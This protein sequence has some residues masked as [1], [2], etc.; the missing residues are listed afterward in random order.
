[1]SPESV[2]LKVPSET[3][4]WAEID[5][6]DNGLSAARIGLKLA[7]TNS[8]TNIYPYE[9]VA[10]AA[11]PEEARQAAAQASP[12]PE[13]EEA[14][15]DALDL[16]FAD[17][18]EAT[19]GNHL[20]RLASATYVRVETPL[21]DA[22]ATWQEVKRQLALPE[23]QSVPDSQVEV[24]PL[25]AASPTMRVWLAY[26]AAD[27]VVVPMW[28]PFAI[29][30]PEKILAWRGIPV[31]LETPE[32]CQ[33]RFLRVV[34]V[35]PE[36]VRGMT[37]RIWQERRDGSPGL[38]TLFGRYPV[39]VAVSVPSARRSTHIYSFEHV[40]KPDWRPG[41]VFYGSTDGEGYPLSFIGERLSQYYCS[42]HKVVEAV[43]R[44]WLA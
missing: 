7:R 17:G 5:P 3:Y 6:D 26:G 10:D 1:M 29:D 8:Y 16:S 33:G 38:G 36:H 2:W 15:D 34:G 42:T 11:V 30:Q 12:A 37:C 19:A 9:P 20:C 4:V 28:P 25:S 24:L 14:T 44:A 43:W 21:D 35:Y 40:R 41:L 27:R 18:A 13:E 23:T 32:P 22:Q 39:D 31:T